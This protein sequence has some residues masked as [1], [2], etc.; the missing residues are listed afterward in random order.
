MD[1][2]KFPQIRQF[3]SK[4]IYVLLI[5]ALGIIL[6]LLPTPEKNDAKVPAATAPAYSEVNSLQEQLSAL[7]SKMDGAGKVQVLLTEAA[8]QTTTYQTDSDTSNS[9]NAESIRNDTVILTDSSRSQ[10]GLVC[11][12][13]PPKYLGAVIL[14]QG[15]DKSSVRLAVTEAVSHATGLGFNSITVLKMK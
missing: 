14:C 6:M 7:L 9:E 13:D 1:Q 11:R 3:F 2:D 8:G 12:V 5:L 10:T 15:A 4:Y